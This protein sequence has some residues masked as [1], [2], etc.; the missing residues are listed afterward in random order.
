M[1]VDFTATWCGPCQRIAPVYEAISEEHSDDAIFLK[2]DVDE[3]AELAAEL[4]VTSMP[5]FLFYRLGEQI[6]SMRGADESLLRELVEKH[7]AG[8]VPV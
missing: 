8:T 4:G 1:V 5:T 2:V 7:T 3:L 6:D